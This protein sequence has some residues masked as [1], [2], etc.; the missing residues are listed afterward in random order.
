MTGGNW[1]SQNKV[2][3]GV[4]INTKSRNGVTTNIGEKGIVAIAEPLDWGRSG[5][6]ME[7]IP[8]E[9]LTPYIGHDIT[10]EA[11]RF[12]REMMKGSDVT[13]GPSK[14]LLYRPAGTS[15]VKASAT[16]GN[17]VVTALYTGTRGNDITIIVS[18]DPDTEGQFDV[19]TVIDGAE[20]DTQTVTAIS[21]LAAND[22]VTF[23]GSGEI[24]ETAGTKLTGG[25]NPTV[26]D[27]D[28]AAFLQAIEPYTFDI[29]VYDGSSANT[30]AAMAQFVTRL[31]DSIGRKCQAVMAGSG[32]AL[33]NKYVIAVHNGVILN[34]GTALSAQQATWWLAGAEAGAL[35]N[36]S[37]TYAQYP[38]AASAN[39]KLTDAQAESAVK[40]GMICFIDEF[41]HVKV[42]TDINTKITITQT[43]GAEYKKN[44]VIRV[45]NQICNDA[46]KQ[47]SENY[48]GKIDNNETG[49]SLFRGWLVGYLNEM[50]ANNGIQNFKAEDVNVLPGASVDSVVIDAFIQP[51]DAVEKIYMTVTVSTGETA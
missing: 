31:N 30:I 2:L 41:E 46:Y 40:T 24:T 33:N 50:Q 3:P 43:E 13:A 19:I 14:I 35:Y 9:D 7:I 15:G 21:G 20:A 11:A 45:L 36:Q 28:H 37:L 27:G 38:G 5:E 23:S 18:E 17:L 29:I 42:C 47:F 12:L 32:A 1:T 4:Y 51:V 26:T 16:I 44:R 48:I 8:G 10:S 39:P 25:V 22:W 6:I 34:D 49:R